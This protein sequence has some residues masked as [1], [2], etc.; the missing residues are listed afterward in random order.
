MN[1][2]HQWTLS[3]H[4]TLDVFLLLYTHLVMFLFHPY[5]VGQAHL[6]CQLWEEQKPVK[7]R[8]TMR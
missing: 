5:S 4:C 6:S 1:F 8:K 7:E 2:T 3:F